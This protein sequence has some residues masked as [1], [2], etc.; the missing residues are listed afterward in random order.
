[1]IGEGW[2]QRT[3][4]EQTIATRATTGEDDDSVGCRRLM[5][6]EV[7]GSRGEVEGNEARGRDARCSE[8]IVRLRL[9]RTLVIVRL[10][11]SGQSSKIARR[12][13]GRLRL[14]LRSKAVATSEWS[15]KAA[16]EEARAGN[17]SEVY[18]RGGRRGS[19]QASEDCARQRMGKS[20]GG[21]SREGKSATAGKRGRRRLAT[22]AGKYGRR[23]MKRKGGTVMA[24]DSPLGRMMLSASIFSFFLA[25]DN[26]KMV[27]NY[28]KVTGAMVM[29]TMA[30]EA[31]AKSQ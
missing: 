4:Q 6:W 23:T 30:R 24:G 3:K 27:R 9:D 8:A 20:N 1:M 16:K 15:S 25:D 31:T 22:E 28:N 13:L 21:Q 26:Y 12:R 17:S 5:G 11:A 19:D 14:R 18:G 29:T 10:A 2:Q 7:I